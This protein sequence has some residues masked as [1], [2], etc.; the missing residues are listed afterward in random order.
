VGTST[1]SIPAT[2]RRASWSYSSQTFS[3][4]PY[5]CP[6]E[7]AS[8]FVARD[9][10]RRGLA[11]VGVVTGDRAARRVDGQERPASDV[12]DPVNVARVRMREFL[13]DAE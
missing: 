10:S 13:A 2:S 8:P 3:A 9:D 11:R 1:H 6:G 7:V 12:G 4:T 5:G